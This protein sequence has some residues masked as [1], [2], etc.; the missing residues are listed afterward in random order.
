[1][2]VFTDKIPI[3][4]PKQVPKEVVICGII[5]LTLLEIVALLCGINGV[6]FTTVV[7]I[8]ALAIG[9]TIPTPKVK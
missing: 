5:A 6:V 9:V 4:M 1:M 8:I 3:K 2:S 7:A